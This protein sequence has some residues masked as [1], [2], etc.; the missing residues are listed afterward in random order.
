VKNEPIESEKRTRDNDDRIEE[1]ISHK[2]NND[3]R[4]Q[5]LYIDKQNNNEHLKSKVFLLDF[6]ERQTNVLPSK[7]RVNKGKFACR[8]RRINPARL[9]SIVCTLAI[10]SP[11]T[12]PM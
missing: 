12:S 2:L 8:A 10:R 3:E 5:V 7:C 4:G 11:S 6:K 9:S 1:H